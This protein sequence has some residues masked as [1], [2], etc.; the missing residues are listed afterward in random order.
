M[1]TRQF[2]GMLTPD[3]CLLALIDY[4]PAMFAGVHSHDRTSIVQN[5]QIVAGKTFQGTNHFVDVAATSFSGPMIPEVSS[6][7]PD[8]TPIDR[9]SINAWLDSNFKDAVEKTGRNKILLSG[10]WTEACVLF[11]AINMLQSGYEVYVTTDAC[12]DITKKHMNGPCSGW[13]NPAPFQ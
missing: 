1:E 13:S 9:T 7:F 2:H 6:V 5:V 3:D 11:P 8:Y 10:L 12:G 4:Q